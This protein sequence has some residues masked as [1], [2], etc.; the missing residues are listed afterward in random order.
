MKQH[1]LLAFIFMTFNF[2]S[3]LSQNFTTLSKQIEKTCHPNFKP[4]G[5]SFRELRLQL[6]DSGKLNFINPKQDT[7]FFLESH[8]IQGGYNGRIWNKKDIVQYDYNSRKGFTFDNKVKMFTDYTIKLIQTWDTLAIREE[9][10]LYGNIN[11]E[12]FISGSRIIIGDKGVIDCIIFKQFFNP[13]RDG[14]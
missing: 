13:K 2:Y 9:E 6:Y 11:P 8:D 10:K 7:L 12:I 3:C 4:K 1:I 14:W 5:I